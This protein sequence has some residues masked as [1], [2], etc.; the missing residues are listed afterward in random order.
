MG[1]FQL[2]NHLKPSQHQEKVP[3]CPCASIKHW[4]KGQVSA[5]LRLLGAR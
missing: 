2:Q 1:Y 3:N 5:P 4:Q